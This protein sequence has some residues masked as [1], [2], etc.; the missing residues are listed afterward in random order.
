MCADLLKKMSDPDW[1]PLISEDLAR[2]VLRAILDD[3][4]KFTEE[5]R[6]GEIQ[7]PQAYVILDVIAS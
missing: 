2:S 3:Q 6:A 7:A 5:R 1:E 4:R